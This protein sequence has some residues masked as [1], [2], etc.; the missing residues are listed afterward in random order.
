MMKYSPVG[1]IFLLL[2]DFMR[3]R[4]LFSLF[5]IAELLNVGCIGSMVWGQALQLASP[6]M[7]IVVNVPDGW[8]V[9]PHETNPTAVSENGSAKL[10]LL[11][12]EKQ[13]LY[14]VMN[15]A[16]V[17]GNFAPALDNAKIVNEEQAVINGLVGAKA[18]GTGMLRGKPVQFKCVIVADRDNKPNTL[19][20]IAVASE[21]AMNQQ[22]RK[23]ATIL[24][25][26]RAK[27][28]K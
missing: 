13:Y 20:V 23:I 7:G 27:N 22:T 4:K 2:E 5:M 9:A 19:L 24:D 25:N 3:C 14:E 21:E 6:Q 1:L 16:K 26:V 8:K 28:A 18:T 15:P 11:F 10:V 12:F 17:A